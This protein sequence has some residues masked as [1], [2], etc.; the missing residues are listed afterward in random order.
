MFTKVINLITI[1][2]MK[3]IKINLNSLINLTILF[4][5]TVV[6]SGCYEEKIIKKSECKS[7]KSANKLIIVNER[8]K[9]IYDPSIDKE[10][11]N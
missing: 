1:F 6:I 3:N 2:L 8:K 11:L 7:S 4:L 5:F 9:L 10:C